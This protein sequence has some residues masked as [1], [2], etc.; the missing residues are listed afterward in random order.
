MALIVGSTARAAVAWWLLGVASVFAGREAI[1]RTSIADKL[2]APW[3]LADTPGAADAIV[4]LAAGSTEQCTPNDYTLR[5]VVL[6][7]RLYAAGRAPRILLTGGVPQGLSCPMAQTMATALESLGVP[8]S[9]LLLEPRAR[10]TRDNAAFSAPVLRNAGVQRILL[11]TDKLHMARAQASFASFGFQIGR[12]SVPIYETG[13][14]NTDMLYWGVREM[15]A[16]RVY[17]WRGWIGAAE[18]D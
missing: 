13:N 1:N 5:R 17:R 14:R 9:A 10:S 8:T 16:W 6:A 7:R 2:V 12:A 3:L 4:V 18:S 11:V 15:I